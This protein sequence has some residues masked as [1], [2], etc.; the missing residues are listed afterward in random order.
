MPW[1]I[2]YYRSES[3]T[4]PG[5]DCLEKDNWPVTVRATMLAVLEAV[6]DAPPPQF[7][8]GGLWEAMHGNMAGFYEVRKQG[9]PARTQYRLF[10]LLDNSD[11]AGLKKRGLSRPAIAVITGMSK[12]WITTFTAGDYASVRA[13]G[14]EYLATF[15]RRIAK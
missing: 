7:S 1:D 12:P 10:C 13:L 11:P 2:L 4:T 8:G 3:G 15:P 6:A 14:D 9:A 5:L